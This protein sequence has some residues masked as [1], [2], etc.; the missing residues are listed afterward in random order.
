M[1]TVCATFGTLGIVSAVL[2]FN[3]LARI[4]NR[5]LIALV[6]SLLFAADC[7][8]LIS[9]VLYYFALQANYTAD[10]SLSEVDQEKAFYRSTAIMSGLFLATYGTAIWIFSFKVWGLTIRIQ[11]M[12]D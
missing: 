7:S 4:K 10:K 5:G 12:L 6:T 2:F 9:R 3:S 8:Y 1:I 11:T